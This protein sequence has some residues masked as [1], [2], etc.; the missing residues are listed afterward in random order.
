MLANLSLSSKVVEFMC[1]VLLLRFVALIGF[2]ITSLLGQA[3]MALNY[4]REQQC[5]IP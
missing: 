5:Q 2:A 3:V 1:F 4:L